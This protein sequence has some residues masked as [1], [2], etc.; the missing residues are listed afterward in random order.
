[1][2]WYADDVEVASDGVHLVRHGAWASSSD[3]EALSI[4]ADGRAVRTYAISDLVD[5][6]FL[7]PHSASHFRWIKGA[8]LDDAALRYVVN[9]EDGNSFVFDVTDGS[10]VEQT[11]YARLKLWAVSIAVL[12]VAGVLIAY[13]VRRKRRLDAGRPATA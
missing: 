2:S 7:L 13:V 5:L 8:R 12:V 1:M 4:F 6:E 10:I 11:R 3:Q 9:T